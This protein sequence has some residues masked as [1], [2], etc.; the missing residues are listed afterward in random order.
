MLVQNLLLL[1]LVATAMMTGILWLVQ[2]VQYPLFLGLNE[3]QFSKWHNLHSARITWI[4]APMM[5][6]ELVI[7]IALVFLNK[8]NLWQN[9]SVV[10][11]T[12][13][14]WGITFFISV[15]RHEKLA[16][17]SRLIQVDSAYR[18]QL[19]V[20]LKSRIVGLDELS[21]HRPDEKVIIREFGQEL[22][23]IGLTPV[24]AEMTP[25]EIELAACTL[26]DRYQSLT[27]PV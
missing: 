8:F 1:Q 11:L 22:R 5:I 13:A 19:A 4:V 14:I 23:T 9:I 25:L 12:V 10:L 21:P 18:E 2:Q 7:S 17:K 27:Q 6:L 15:P 26:R 24:R 20:A 16:Q 3:S